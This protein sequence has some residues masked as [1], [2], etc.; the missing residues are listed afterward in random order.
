MQEKRKMRI[1]AIIVGSGWSVGSWRHPDAD[2][3]A[4]YSIDYFTKIAE[5]A[6]AGKFDYIFFGDELFISEK[7]HPNFLNRLD[8]LSLVSAL[9]MKTSKL[10]LAA[11]LS[12]TFNEPFNAAR[13]TASI[14]KISKGRFG[15]NVVTSA[16]EGAAANFG[17]KTLPNHDERYERADEFVEVCKGLW[18]SW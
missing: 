9:S 17:M 12:T 15:W 4:P 2:P 11:T 8:V 10:G 3:E 6:E 14:D 5:T 13:Q 7:S 18:N 16:L 1:G